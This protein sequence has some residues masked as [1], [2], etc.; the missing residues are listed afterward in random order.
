MPDEAIVAGDGAAARAG[1]EVILEWVMGV[2]QRFVEGR[3]D[4]YVLANRDGDRR[5]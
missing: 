1:M 4:T 5:R 3:E 2:M